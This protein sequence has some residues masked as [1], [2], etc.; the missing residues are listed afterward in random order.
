MKTNN[1]H[2]IAEQDGKAERKFKTEI[3]RFLYK[4]DCKVRAYLVK[5]N[6]KNDR[7]EF[8]VALCFNN[9]LNHKFLIDCSTKIFKEIFCAS[10]HLN[11]IFIDK[12]ME[13]RI[14]KIACPFYISLNNQFNEP[15]FYLTSSEGY[16]LETIRSCF[17]RKN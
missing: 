7:A 16:N 10:E 11:I 8:N 13:K 6:Y 4:S 12:S 9:K 5:L 17:K 15:D 14:R 2:F 3:N 1:I